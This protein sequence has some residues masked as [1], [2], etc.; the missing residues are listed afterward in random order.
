MLIVCQVSEFCCRKIKVSA[1][2]VLIKCA[3]VRHRGYQTI[4]VDFDCWRILIL[5][6]CTQ[7][8]CLPG[9]LP[10]QSLLL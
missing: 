3:G 8:V 6:T 1:Q 10:K 2:T 5:G 9:H 4:F 7:N